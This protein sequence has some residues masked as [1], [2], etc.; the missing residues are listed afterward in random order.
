ML[1]YATVTT[2]EK[3]SNVHKHC[4]VYGHTAL[5]MCPSTQRCLVMTFGEEVSSNMH[6][7]FETELLKLHAK[8]NRSRV[9]IH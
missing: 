6:K 5:A 4:C 7:T 8:L 1:H 9:G 3:A 2:H